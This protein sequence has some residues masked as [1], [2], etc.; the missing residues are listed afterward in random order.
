MKKFTA[1]CKENGDFTALL[2]CFGLGVLICITGAICAHLNS[3]KTAFYDGQILLPDHT[4][5]DTL[6]VYNAQYLGERLE[7]AKA[8]GSIMELL[9]ETCETIQE[10]R[11]NQ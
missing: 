7:G 6:V 11:D 2:L 8:D 4:H 9:N 3:P 10:Y 1:Y 5:S